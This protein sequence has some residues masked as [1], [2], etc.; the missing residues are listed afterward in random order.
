VVTVKT[1]LVAPW[2]IVT[3]TGTFATVGYELVRL[4]TNP[5]EGAA[6]SQRTTPLTL[7]PPI[8]E[9]VVSSMLWSEMGVTL[10]VC[11]RFTPPRLAVIVVN[12]VLVTALAVIVK[13]LLEAPCG[14]VTDVGTVAAFGLLFVNVTTAPPERAGPF[15]VTV[16]MTVDRSNVVFVLSVKPLRTSG[17]SWSIACCEL[18]PRIAEICTR[19]GA[20]TVWVVTVNVAELWPVA[21]VTVAGTAARA[22]FVE[23]NVTTVLLVAG[24]ASVT[25]P[26]IVFPPTAGFGVTER[27][28]NLWANTSK[29]A[30]RGMPW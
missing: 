18:A 8:T 12:W 27:P 11:W 5:P 22:G 2:G 4:T 7:L 6:A 29:S 21:T 23:D 20:F 14:T 24:P 1:A 28:L 15:S 13:V 16:P 10:R 30:Y 26:W 19:A 3:D 9:V 17:L 25:R